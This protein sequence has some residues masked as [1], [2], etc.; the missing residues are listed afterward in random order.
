MRF[1]AL[2]FVLLINT[3][4]ADQSAEATQPTSIDSAAA[5]ERLREA[6]PGIPVGTVEPAPVPGMFQVQVR[7]EWLYLT[8]DGRFVFAGELFELRPEGAVSLLEERQQALREPAIAALDETA[9]IT[10]PAKQQKAEVY[11]FTDT[12]CGYCRLMHRQMAAYNRAGITVH[13]LA[14]PRGGSA[15]P[16]ARE[17]TDIWCSPDRNLAMDEAKLEKPLSQKP[18]TCDAPVA[19]HYALGEEFGVRGTPAVFTADG[20]QIGGYLPADRMAEKLGLR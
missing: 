9:L 13:Y 8:A 7:G 17:L 19:A 14:F 16:G 15:S 11:V 18:T 6:F 20:E 2:L 1:F 10:F 12:T 3:A 4:C 5:V